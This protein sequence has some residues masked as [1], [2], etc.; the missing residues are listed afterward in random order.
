[1]TSGRDHSALPAP[2]TIDIAGRGSAAV[3]DC[4]PTEPSSPSAAPLLLLHGWNVDA[5]L[6]FASVVPALTQNRRV[7][8]F[9]HHGHGRGV[10]A[11][12]SFDLSHCAD[13]AVAVLDALDI[14]RAVVVGYSLGGAVAQVMANG[15]RHRCEALVLMATA[16]TFAENRREAA[17][18]SFLDQSARAMRRLPPRPRDIAFR[19]ISGVA[20]RRYPPWILD[21][22]RAANPVTLLEAGAQLGRFDATTW[23]STIEPPC[24]VVVTSADTVVSPARQH[25]LARHVNATEVIEVDA[26]H[27]LPI[28]NDPRFADALAR[29]VEAVASVAVSGSLG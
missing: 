27:D 1:M 3:W 25:A 2:I 12:S 8:M 24:A 15:H 22:V 26:D 14:E 13:D 7:V 21:T 5:P 9:D 10:R 18:F 4:A 29:A 20:C 23:Q 16:S 28:R 19:R 17:Q 6:N 11:D